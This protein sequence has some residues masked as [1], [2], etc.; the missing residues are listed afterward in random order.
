MQL[1]VIDKKAKKEGHVGQEHV[2]LSS[3]TVFAHIHNLQASMST[4]PTWI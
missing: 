3:Q 1:V 2:H 4:Y